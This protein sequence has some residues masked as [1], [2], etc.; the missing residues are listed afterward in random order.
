MS[1]LQWPHDAEL[2]RQRLEHRLRNQAVAYELTEADVQTCLQR[3]LMEHSVT[4]LQGVSTADEKQ[5]RHIADAALKSQRAELERRAHAGG[6]G[7]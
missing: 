4:A 2:F 3:I 5:L 7:Q 1:A 6:A